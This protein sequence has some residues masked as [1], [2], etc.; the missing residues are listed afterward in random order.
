MASRRACSVPF[1]ASVMSFSTNGRTALALATVVMIRSWRNSAS[2]RLRISARR[3]EALRPSLRPALR[4]RMSFIPLPTSP[5]RQQEALACAAGCLSLLP[6][7]RRRQFHAQLQVALF[8]FGLHFL[9]G[10]FAEVADL[11]QLLVGADHQV[12]HRR[13]AL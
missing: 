6:S 2:A 8:E 5:E 11:Q 10:R 13:D 1:L 7:Q 4:C 9:Q 3:W 12:A